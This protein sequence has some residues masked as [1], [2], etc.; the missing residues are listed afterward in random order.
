MA[1]QTDKKQ[2]EVSWDLWRH[3]IGIAATTD[4]FSL[5]LAHDRINADICRA[6]NDFSTSTYPPLRRWFQ[7]PLP[8]LLGQ[9]LTFKQDWL[10]M[11]LSFRAQH[12]DP[13]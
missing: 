7:Q 9:H 10:L 1:V 4:S 6:Y 8:V 12:H 2:W 5:A 11:V 3:R 13:I